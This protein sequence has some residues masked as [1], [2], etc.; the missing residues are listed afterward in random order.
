MD[1]KWEVDTK[2]FQQCAFCWLWFLSGEDRLNPTR[3]GRLLLDFQ[4]LAMA[5]VTQSRG[6]CNIREESVL[7]R[8]WNVLRPIP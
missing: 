3:R 1:I 8:D 5:G 7:L 2:R 6:K 4:R